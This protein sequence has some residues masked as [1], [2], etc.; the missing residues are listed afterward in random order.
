MAHN[1][2]LQA[3]ARH[4]LR[5][6]AYPRSLSSLGAPE[7]G[8]FGSAIELRALFWLLPEK[9]PISLGEAP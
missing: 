8:E 6:P 5:V 2:V 1:C 4:L 7:R 3:T 9:P